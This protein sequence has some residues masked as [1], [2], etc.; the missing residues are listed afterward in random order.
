MYPPQTA[1]PE[2]IILA[3]VAKRTKVICWS[4]YATR[5]PTRF[6]AVNVVLVIPAGSAKAFASFNSGLGTTLM[7]GQFT[8]K[9]QTF[10]Y[11]DAFISDCEGRL[12]LSVRTSFTRT[13]I[14]WL[15]FRCDIPNQL[16]P[17]LTRPNL[18][19]MSLVI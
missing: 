9:T 14:H 6:D 11:S 4:C 17:F 10:R 7:S 12:W 3:R 18:P 16:I 2:R 5:K 1:S 13:N 15:A 8:P 19:E